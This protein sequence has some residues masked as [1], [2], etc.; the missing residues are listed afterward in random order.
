[1]KREIYLIRHGET[2]WNKERRFQ[3]QTDIPLN[4][5]G[6]RQA[7]SLRESLKGKLP[8]DRII[9]SDLCRARETA[10]IINEGSQSPI[11][12]D[13]AFRELCFGKWEGMVFPDIKKEYPLEAKYWSTAPHLLH[14]SGGESLQEL[15]GRVWPRFIYWTQLK[16]Y[17]SMAVVCHGGTC[18]A[19]LCGLLNKPLSELVTYIHGNTALNVAELN[20]N[21]VYQMARVNDQSHL[22]DD[23]SGEERD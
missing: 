14:I 17:R 2:D 9:C 21:G 12:I 5:N 23:F 15:F 18:G 6:R 8:F 16:D 22:A 3:G 13:P 10:E 11:I 1:M 4:D 7:K 20:E 19:L